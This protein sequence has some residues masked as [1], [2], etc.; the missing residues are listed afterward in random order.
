[1]RILMM[2]RAMRRRVITAQVSYVSYAM[3]INVHMATYVL[4]LLIC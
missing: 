2:S 3:Q 1:M 4:S